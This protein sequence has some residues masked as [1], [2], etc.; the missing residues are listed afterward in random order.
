VPGPGQYVSDPTAGISDPKELPQ[1][2][3]VRRRRNFKPLPCP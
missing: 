1:A 2:K 3:I